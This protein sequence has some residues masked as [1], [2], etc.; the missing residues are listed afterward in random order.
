MVAW[1]RL[2]QI[3]GGAHARTRP[4]S[5]NFKV[6]ALRALWRSSI[7]SS[8]CLARP[9]VSKCILEAGLDFWVGVA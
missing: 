2:P 5:L 3:L 8:A 4:G 1:P 9:E 7:D 6:P